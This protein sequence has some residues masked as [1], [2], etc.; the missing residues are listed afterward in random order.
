MTK[1]VSLMVD[2]ALFALGST[3]FTRYQSRFQM[4]KLILCISVSLLVLVPTQ[5][6]ADD[7]VIQIN[8]TWQFVVAIEADRITTYDNSSAM[9]LVI[10]DNSWALFKK[11]K[12][13]QGTV[14]NVR[15]NKHASPVSFVRQK[16]KAPH[17]VGEGILKVVGE[18]LMYT[19]TPMDATRLGSKSG[20]VGDYDP[21]LQSRSPAP[22]EP[23]DQEH[24]GGEKH[25]KPPPKRF[26]PEG[27]SNTQYILRRIN[28][29]TSVMNQITKR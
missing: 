11:G 5:V 14:E 28:D 4:A 2:L 25:S 21:D 10:L 15:Y 7:P 22:R 12:L 19:I 17:V 23:L 20:A 9:Q 6:R 27:T 29:S 13:I 1:T 16:G 18:H 8:G 3:A 24:L 26:S